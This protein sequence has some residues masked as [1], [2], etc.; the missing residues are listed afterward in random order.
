MSL[1]HRKKTHEIYL[2]YSSDKALSH[3]ATRQTNLGTDVSPLLWYLHK[4]EGN[5]EGVETYLFPDHDWAH[6]KVTRRGHIDFHAFRL[7]AFPSGLV[8]ASLHT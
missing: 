1:F 7:E 2:A 4:H 3:V 6:S 5:G 8:F